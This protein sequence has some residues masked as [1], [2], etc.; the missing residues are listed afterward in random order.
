MDNLFA[1][2]ALAAATIPLDLGLIAAVK[3]VGMPSKF[4]P[5]ASIALGVGLVALTGA[6]WQA[7]I[8]QGI[9]VG[10][11][12]SGLWSGGK[13]LF[14]TDNSLPPPPPPAAAG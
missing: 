10:L 12:A 13:A 5:L 11:A 7:D 3:Q 1:L 6:A 2:S 8:A 14:S 4:A 9:V